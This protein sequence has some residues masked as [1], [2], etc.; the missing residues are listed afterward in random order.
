MGR[1]L[2]FGIPAWLKPKP[3]AVPYITKGD[4]GMIQLYVLDPI[5]FDKWRRDYLGQGDV[6]RHA[7]AFA[8]W[9][10]ESRGYREGF[11]LAPLIVLRNDALHLLAHEL[12]HLEDGHWHD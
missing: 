7:K 10:R 3:T 12:K 4:T 2:T 8:V 5:A 11:R 1:K 6:H 9:E